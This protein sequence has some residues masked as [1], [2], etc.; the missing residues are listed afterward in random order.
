MA[1]PNEPE[2]PVGRQLP[3]YG[4]KKRATSGA[5]FLGVC[6]MVH[7]RGARG[8]LVM[9]H[10][11][12]LLPDCLGKAIWR[13]CSLGG[14]AFLVGPIEPFDLRRDAHPSGNRMPGP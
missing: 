2:P 8:L 10:W 11:T 12:F 14:F 3:C 7:I 13:I 9:P 5:L 6:E 4:S 1:A